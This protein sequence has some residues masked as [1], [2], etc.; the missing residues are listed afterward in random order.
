MAFEIPEAPLLLNFHLKFWAG[1][2][3]LQ[4]SVTAA[5]GGV[6]RRFTLFGVPQEMATRLPAPSHGPHW[7]GSESGHK[8]FPGCCGNLS[9]SGGYGVSAQARLQKLEICWP[10]LREGWGEKWSH[11]A[12]SRHW[13]CCLGRDLCHFSWMNDFSGLFCSSGALFEF[14]NGWFSHFACILFF[15]VSY[16][17]ILAAILRIYSLAC[18]P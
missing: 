7:P 8:N 11:P 3:L 18:P 17:R 1:L 13:P 16:V 10:P 5:S 2:S 12:L 15:E 6:A 4:L 9:K 14:L